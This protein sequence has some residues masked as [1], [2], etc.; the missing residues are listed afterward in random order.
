MNPNLRLGHI[1]IGLNMAERTETGI[2]VFPEALARIPTAYLPLVEKYRWAMEPWQAFYDAQKTHGFYPKGGLD[3]LLDIPQDAFSP[4]NFVNRKNGGYETRRYIDADPFKKHIRETADRMEEVASFAVSEAIPGSYLVAP[5]LQSQAQA[6]RRGEFR[7][8]MAHRL[9]VHN[10]PAVEL[11]I[12]LM[13]RYLD[14]RYGAKLA[15]QSWV[16]FKDNEATERDERIVRAALD[17][18][19]SRAVCRVL[20]GEV[21]YFGGLA[22]DRNWAG[23]TA[24]SEDDLRTEIAALSFLFH[25]VMAIKLKT[26]LIPGMLQYTPQVREIEGWEKIAADA[27][28][29]GTVLHEFGHS[30]VNF[31]RDAA[32]LLQGYYTPIKELMSEQQ[33][34]VSGVELPDHLAGKTL[35]KM[36]LLARFARW[37]LFLDEFLAETDPDK[38]RIVLAYAR[39]FEWQVNF[40]ER[41]KSIS[42][43]G[44]NGEIT[45]EDYDLVAAKDRE[46]LGHLKGSVSDERHSPGSVARVVDLYSRIP[47]RY[48]PVGTLE[49]NCVGIPAGQISMAS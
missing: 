18:T 41:D 22:G 15:A 47:R 44:D 4:Y 33:G 40:H 16:V 5:T 2:V 8:M 38:K 42:V 13:D 28:E 12:F 25:N 36:I 49:D 48:I 46:L 9:N 24:P 1:L 35:K 10:T 11:D 39:A 43:N 45:I 37:R 7:N 19:N 20:A 23:N 29:I 27:D 34:R 31:D 26:N 32:S 3:P 21:I 17:R 30:Q 6:L 14:P